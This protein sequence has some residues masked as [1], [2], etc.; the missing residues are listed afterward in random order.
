MR[1]GDLAG[2]AMSDQQVRS[3]AEAQARINV[4]E[5]SIR[6]GKTIG[7]LVRWLMH[8]AAV[9]DLPGELFMF[10]RTRDSVA[11]NVF[12]PLTTPALFGP[13][14]RHINYTAGAPTAT[15]LGQNVHVLGANDK[16]AE[17]KVRGLTGKGAYG[18]E[19]TTIPAPF[20]KQ[21]LGRLSVEGAKLYGTTNPDNPAHWLRQEYLLDPDLNLRSWHFTIDDNVHHLGREFV[22]NL[23][24]EY[25]GLWYKRFILGLWVQAEGAI[26]EMFDEARHV[27][28]EL[29]PIARVLATGI[30]Y[31]TTNPFAA[32]T[33]ALTADG[34]L[35]F[36]REYRHDPRK[37]RKQ[38][39]DAEF[40]AELREW[41]ARSDPPRWL[42]ID[43]SAESF[44]L[45]LHRDGVRGIAD[46]DNAVADGIRLFASL[47]AT[48]RLVIHKSCAG[49]IGEIPG[50]VWDDKAA[51]KGEDRPVKKDDHSVDA[52]RYAVTTTHAAWRRHVPLTPWAAGDK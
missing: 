24:T 34:R 35:C 37:A 18:D 10:G 21:T 4:W 46:A 31:G 17:E 26:Y 39:T 33:L 14:V 41:L 27:V 52:A 11:R 19:L 25:K 51:E 5:G 28:D 32:V 8:V 40:S 29:P 7:S 44:Q 48:D 23:K 9:R 36:T 30:D 45:Q 1:A 22:E 6:S 16:Q 42:A 12:G 47:L 49:L 13:I 15:I 50:Y 43:P 20:F 3:I 38:L 2:G